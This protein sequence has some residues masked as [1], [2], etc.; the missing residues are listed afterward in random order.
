MAKLI[1]DPSLYH[2]LL[3]NADEVSNTLPVPVEH[4]AV[5]PLTVIAGVG[6]KGVITMVAVLLD[7]IG[8]LQVQPVNVIEVIVMSLDD[9]ERTPV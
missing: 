1:A 5:G 4:I 3:D 6:G 8:V 7:V 9:P 2:W